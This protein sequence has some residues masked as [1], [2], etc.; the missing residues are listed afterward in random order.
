MKI[1]ATLLLLGFALGLQD[2]QLLNRLTNYHHIDDLHNLKLQGIFDRFDNIRKNKFVQNIDEAKANPSLKFLGKMKE[3]KKHGMRDILEES[4]EEFNYNFHFLELF[5][6]D[7][8]VT[9]SFRGF[10]K[11][12]K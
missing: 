5:R 11:R 8:F 9:D 3:T 1:F 6:Q 10:K 12:L 4:T 7:S 2:N